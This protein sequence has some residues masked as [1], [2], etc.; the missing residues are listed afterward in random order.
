[1]A[2]LIP[3]SLPHWKKAVDRLLIALPMI[4]VIALYHG[5]LHYP[6]VFDDVPFFT[7]ETLE[8]LGH[9]PFLFQKRWVAYT[10]FG[11]TYRLF[12]SDL[13]WYRAGNIVLHGL[14][15]T[16]LYV[17][18]AR[19]YRA[20]LPAR[21]AG[22]APCWL[23]C[24]GALL[25]ACHPAAVYGVAYLIQRSTVMA[26]LF[27]IVMLTCHLA[28][29]TS[30]RR[31]WYIAAAAGYLLAVYSKEHALMLPAVAAAMTLLVRRTSNGLVR[32][33]WMPYALYA[34]IAVTAIFAWRDMLGTIAESML[35]S[36]MSYGEVPGLSQEHAFAH[37]IL[38]LRQT[39]VSRS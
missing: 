15:A 20:V 4:V 29:L 24:V 26:T 17:F 32:E 12:G 21:Q 16:A 31:W 30:T 37:S 19:L 3:M 5:S 27:G 22:A 11:W 34:A 13:F 10:S 6:L 2:P 1:M 23:A 7:A 9:A 18:F 25:F 8:G 14:V 38:N 39:E 35:I 36:D 33:L 28:G